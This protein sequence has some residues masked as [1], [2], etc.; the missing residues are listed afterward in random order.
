MINTRLAL[1][2][3]LAFAVIPG[4][5]SETAAAARDTAATIEYLLGQVA[6]SDYDFIRNSETHNG[7]KAADHMRRK[8]EHFADKINTPEDFI[9]LAA[10]KS[11]MT[12]RLYTVR[13]PDGEFATAQWLRE[14]LAEYRRG[15]TKD[16]KTEAT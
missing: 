13:T 12:D 16:S 11:L 9:D 2:S 3:L 8:Y 7:E 14:V 15:H 6:T 10:T 1:M 5:T 4:W